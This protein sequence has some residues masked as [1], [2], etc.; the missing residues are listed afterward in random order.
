MND[1]AMNYL[2]YF[3]LGLL[4][5]DIVAS[6]I[7]DGSFTTWHVINVFAALFCAA[8]LATL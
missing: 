2:F 3:V 8:K 7:K 4:N 6:R 5:T 1:K